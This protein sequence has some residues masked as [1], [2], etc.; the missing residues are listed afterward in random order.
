MQI[1]Y[2]LD[3]RL[4][5]HGGVLPFVLADIA[6]KI[7]PDF[8]RELAH[9]LKKNEAALTNEEISLARNENSE[10][11]TLDEIAKELNIRLIEAVITDDFSDII[12]N[13]GNVHFMPKK[14][15]DP[16]Y[17]PAGVLW[18]DFDDEL[19]LVDDRFLIPMIVGHKE[20]RGIRWTPSGKVIDINVVHLYG[21]GRNS[22][23]LIQGQDDIFR[24]VYSD[25]RP[26]QTVHQRYLLP[27]P[28]AQP[29]R[30]LITRI[31]SAA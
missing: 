15:G 26:I 11:L 2:V 4:V 23:I 25:G 31:D 1:A 30:R 17:E 12:F 18:A 6:R 16:D 28:T 21:R 29:D 10:A 14:R 19:M 9:R 3:G 8:V 7:K 27:A 24:A 13:E 22:G 5:V 20:G